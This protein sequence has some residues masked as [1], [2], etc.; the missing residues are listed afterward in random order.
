MVKSHC[1][2]EHSLR[3]NHSDFGVDPVYNPDPEYLSPDPD[4]E[5]LK[6]IFLRNIGNSGLYLPGG[7]SVISGGFRSLIIS[8]YW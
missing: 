2:T 1:G 6:Q 8:I 4:S 3:T 5:I 7:S